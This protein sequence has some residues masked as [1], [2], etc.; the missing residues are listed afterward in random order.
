MAD[1]F[2]KLPEEASG[3]PPSV[4]PSTS[5]N[6]TPV[7]PPIISPLAAAAAT[8]VQQLPGAMLKMQQQGQPQPDANNSGDSS[9]SSS[10]SSAQ[11]Q[12]NAPLPI[13]AFP[14]I[15]SLTAAAASSMAGAAKDG[16]KAR[17]L[18]SWKDFI[19][20]KSKYGLPSVSE[21]SPRIKSNISSF[22]MNYIIVVGIL[23][24][25]FALT[26]FLFLLICSLCA[27]IWVYFF[28]WRNSPVV[29]AGKTVPPKAVVAS[30]LLGTFL[31]VWYAIGKTIFW[32][33]I[34][35]S[36]GILTHAGLYISKEEIID[37]SSRGHFS[38]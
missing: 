11:N 37:F 4:P 2:Q 21:L 26:N 33:L 32:I 17:A 35:S 10:S 15:A 20:D 31:L 34:F 19:G 18:V 13:P 29:I 5:A 1:E 23:M 16:L 36:I 30:L 14:S 38:V 25:F 22:Y 9:N 28:W 6:T 12:P 24:L 8:L 7:P 27:G 3:I